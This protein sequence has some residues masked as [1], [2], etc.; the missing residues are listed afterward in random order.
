MQTTRTLTE[1]M[2]E[3]LAEHR[4]VKAWAA[5]NPGRVEPE[6]IEV[7]KFKRLES[8]SAVYRLNGVGPGGSAV[9]AKRCR[10]VTAAVERI[11]YG[12]FLPQLPLPAVRYYGHVD[13][14]GGEACW[15]F[16]EHAGG[17]EYSP[18]DAGHRSL[19]A[20]WL[21]SIQAAAVGAGLEARLPARDADYY[22]KLLRSTRD[23]LGEHFS[24]PELF[25][26]EVETLRNL[27]S[28]FDAIEA[29]WPELRDTCEGL[30]PTLV[31]GDFVAKN[32]R[33][34]ADSNGPALLVFDWE[35]AGWG[36]PATD[37]SQFIGRTVSPDLGVYGALVNGPLRAYRG[38]IARRLAECGKCFRLID[39]IQWASSALTF[40]PYPLLEKPM[41]YL[42]SYEPRVREALRELNWNNTIE[43]CRHA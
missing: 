18:L 7:L 21:A 28:Q 16:L 11:I 15:L 43:E 3:R 26:V 41:S 29:H 25:A 39:K 6:S 37:L 2:P 12:E 17:L 14:P 13:E 33:L 9:V 35:Y 34:R 5:L 40:G 32:V 36:V 31:H 1:V 30:P 8:K 42:K 20:R 27:S 10:A 19:A 24:N 38:R 23:R 22:L 4:A